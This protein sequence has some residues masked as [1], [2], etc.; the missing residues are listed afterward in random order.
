MKKNPFYVYSL[1]DPRTKPAK[2]FYIGKAQ[3]IAFGSMKEIPKILI[4]WRL[5]KK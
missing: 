3:V 5:L 2:P 4:K 1:K